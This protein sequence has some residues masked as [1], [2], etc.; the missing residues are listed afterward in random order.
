MKFE[1]DPAK[2]FSNKQKHE[3]DFI[4]GQKIWDSPTIELG[5][6]AKNEERHL[7]I[8]KIETTFWTAIITYRGDAIRLISIRRSR[9]EEK[10]KFRKYYG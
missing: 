2:S 4:E 8:G 3:I 6:R 10:E 1:F 5:S 9:D 7:V